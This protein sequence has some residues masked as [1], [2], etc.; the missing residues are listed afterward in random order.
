MEPSPAPAG[1]RALAVAPG[2]SPDAHALGV[3]ESLLNYCTRVDAP[4][5]A[6]LREKVKRLASDASEEG[7]A[8]IR[9]SDEY[10][11]A[12]DAVGEFVAKIDE[13]NAKRVCSESPANG[14][15]R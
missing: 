4:A 7:L 15:G 2:R 5:A 1:Q 6:K 12:Y 3:T 13:H 14:P 9:R 8:A 11:K 10:R